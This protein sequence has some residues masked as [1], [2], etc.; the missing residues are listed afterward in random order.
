MKWKCAS[1]GEDNSGDYLE[2]I[3][4]EKYYDSIVNSEFVDSYSKI[5]DNCKPI[6]VTTQYIVGYD[7]EATLGIV[8]SEY[9]QGL[10]IVGDLSAGVTDAFGGRNSRIEKNVSK[11]RIECLNELRFNAYKLGADAVVSINVSCSSFPLSNSSL[12]VTTASG[13]AVKVVKDCK[14]VSPK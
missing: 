11:S 5:S 14:S 13:T 10:S 2:C 12:L 8:A 6:L 9:V 4:G 7:I 3:C 1:C